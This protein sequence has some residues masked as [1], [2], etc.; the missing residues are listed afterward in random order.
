MGFKIVWWVYRPRKV[1]ILNF[2]ILYFLHCPII[3]VSYVKGSIRSYVPEFY[4]GL[5]EVFLFILLR[6][7]GFLKPPSVRMEPWIP[8][9]ERRCLRS[10]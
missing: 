6:I 5:A 7:K 4:G 3:V 10:Y 9:K 1:K 2:C 8:L